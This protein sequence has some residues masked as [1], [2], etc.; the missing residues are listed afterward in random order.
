MDLKNNIDPSLI[1]DPLKNLKENMK[2]SK[3]SFDLKT[4][5]IKELK[6]SMKQLKSKK[7]CGN[8]GLSQAQLKAGMSELAS[9]LPDI[10]NI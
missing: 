2:D 3:C 7:S 4:V 10:I 8:D 9:P 5:S 1:K 6:S